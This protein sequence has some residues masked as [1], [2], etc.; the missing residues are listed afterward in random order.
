MD[1]F[2]YSRRGNIYEIFNNNGIL[3]SHDSYIEAE[4]YW[5]RLNKNFRELAPMM[6]AEIETM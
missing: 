1:E 2:V 4:K 6:G 5:D 3:F